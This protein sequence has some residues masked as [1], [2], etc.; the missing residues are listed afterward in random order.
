VSCED[1]ELHSAVASHIQPYVNH[2]LERYGTYY[3]KD[4]IMIMI[5]K[6]IIREGSKIEVYEK[7]LFEMLL[8]A[9]FT[10]GENQNSFTWPDN[11]IL[12]NGQLAIINNDKTEKLFGDI[13]WYG[14]FMITE[15]VV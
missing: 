2:L 11:W 6:V 9:G 14:F 12:K 15:F 3:G 1:N 10:R 13:Y 5:R 7:K 4:N 8:N